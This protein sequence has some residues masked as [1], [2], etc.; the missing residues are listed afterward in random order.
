[1]LVSRVRA[2]FLR[3]TEGLSAVLLAHWLMGAI[4]FLLGSPSHDRISGLQCG[5]L[6][7][8]ASLGS[9]LSSEIRSFQPAAG[10]FFPAQP[11]TSKPSADLGRVSALPDERGVRNE[12]LRPGG[13]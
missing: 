1:M 13:A 4:L 5:V 12:L 8:Q 7:G 9:L 10:A 2:H 3:Q 6:S 11:L